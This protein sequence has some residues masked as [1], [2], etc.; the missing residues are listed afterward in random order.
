MKPEL[1][2]FL[3]VAAGHVMTRTMPALQG[4]EQS[5][6]GVLGMLLIEASAEQ[7]RGAQRRVEENAVLR[8][9]FADAAGVIDAAPLRKRLLHAAETRDDSLLISALEAGNAALRG[10]LIEL[11]AHVETLDTEGARRIEAAIWRE[12]VAS[13]ERRRISFGAF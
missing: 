7:E 8:A 9:L 13:T 2:K 10:L 5:S 11:H 1:G 6:M 4:Y 3:Q 12:L